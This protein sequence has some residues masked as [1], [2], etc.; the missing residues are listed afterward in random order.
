MQFDTHTHTLTHTRTADIFMAPAIGATP[1]GAN[2]SS[3]CLMWDGNDTQILI[4]IKTT[5]NQ[6]DACVCVCCVFVVLCVFVMC[7]CRA[8]NCDRGWRANCNRVRNCDRCSR[9]ICIRE[10]LGCY[11]VCVCCVF[12]VLCVFVMFVCV[13]QETVTE[14]GGNTA[15]GSETATHVREQSGFANTIFAFVVCLL[16]C[17]CV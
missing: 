13:V 10:F 17:V 4:K 11:L 14:V 12:V 3:E 7:V 5:D 16:C 8:G 1:D 9:A 6:E 15:T 2:N